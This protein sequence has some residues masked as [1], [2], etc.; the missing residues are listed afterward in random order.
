MTDEIV[1]VRCRTCHGSR[2]VPAPKDNAW[3][4]YFE[5]IGRPHENVLV[6][7]QKC[8]ANGEAARDRKE[9]T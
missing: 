6:P 5:R 1:V 4:K 9:G 2:Y 7:C 8:D 3:R